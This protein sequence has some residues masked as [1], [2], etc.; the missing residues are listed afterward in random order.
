M[1][2][3]GFLDFLSQ[4]EK[5]SHSH[6]RN[7]SF[8]NLPPPAGMRGR[9][10]HQVKHGPH[11][12][13]GTSPSCMFYTLSRG[14]TRRTAPSGK[15]VEVVLRDSPERLPGSLSQRPPE[16]KP[17]TKSRPP[18]T[19]QSTLWRYSLWHP[20]LH[21]QREG[22][23]PLQN[24]PLL[25]DPQRKHPPRQSQGKRFVSAQLDWKLPHLGPEPFSFTWPLR[26]PTLNSRVSR[27]K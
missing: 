19:P 10:A 8:M 9:H 25:L 13:G 20:G 22:C 7:D 21:V 1:L 17:H 5:E 18:W 4:W 27:G 15:A 24:V 14:P 2:E 23:L 12:G 26:G 16:G 6:R 11:L 3:D